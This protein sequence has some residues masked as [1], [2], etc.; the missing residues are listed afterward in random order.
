MILLPDIEIWRPR[1][2]PKWLWVLAYVGC[3][4]FERDLRFAILVHFYC[5]SLAPTDQKKG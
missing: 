2:C 1:W 3:G 4:Q 5:P